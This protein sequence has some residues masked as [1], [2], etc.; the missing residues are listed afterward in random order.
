MTPG[1]VYSVGRR[2]WFKMTPEEHK[3]RGSYITDG[4]LK[5]NRLMRGMP[6]TRKTPAL[7]A[8]IEAMRNV[9][10]QHAAPLPGHAVLYRGMV[11]PESVAAQFTVGS[12]VRD[13]AFMSTTSERAITKAFRWGLG[14]AG[15]YGMQSV[16]MR[17]KAPAG[18][19]VLAGQNQE[20]ELILDADTPMR[21][22][23]VSMEND[24]MIV[25]L[26]IVQ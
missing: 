11:A 20:S 6:D 26:E 16:L 14:G 9:M 17:I 1:E 19:K 2:A 10:R 23:G 12:V 8:K 5:M 4:F 21:V 7:L 24:E 22:T 3:A 15:K 13:K 18:T 25:D